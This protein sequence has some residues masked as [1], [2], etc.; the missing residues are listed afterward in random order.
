MSANEK[1][2]EFI[3]A[4]SAQMEYFTAIG[5]YKEEIK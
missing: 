1:S 4:I 2:E 5:T 3:T